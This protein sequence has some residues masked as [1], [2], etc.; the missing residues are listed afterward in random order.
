MK[1]RP[2]NNFYGLI[3]LQIRAEAAYLYDA[4]ML[5][6]SAV[7]ETHN[8]GGDIRNGT[9]IIEKIRCRHYQS[10]MGWVDQDGTLI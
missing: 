10:A 4:V 3:S 1:H 2:R 6:A 5:Y 7:L 8:A 9:A